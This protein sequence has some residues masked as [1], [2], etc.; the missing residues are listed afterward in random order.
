MSRQEIG[1]YFL[2]V[3][4]RAQDPKEAGGAR[5]SKAPAETAESVGRD[6][7]PGATH[8]QAGGHA[9]YQTAPHDSP[10]DVTG[11]AVLD[12]GHW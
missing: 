1:V 11:R 12:L 2:T 7:C 9:P 4:D 3:R 5:R 8:T 10:I 6:P